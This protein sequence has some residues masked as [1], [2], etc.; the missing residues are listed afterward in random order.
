MENIIEFFSNHYKL[1]IGITGILIFSLIGYFVSEKRKK[2]NTFKLDNQDNN[3]ELNIGES[4][5][6]SLQD[7]IRG[8]A[9]I[10]NE[11]DPEKL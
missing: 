9:T 11:I 3:M 1:F 5:N 4:Q 2:N 10:K 8:K 6:M 7:A